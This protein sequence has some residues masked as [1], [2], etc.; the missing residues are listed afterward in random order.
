MCGGSDTPRI[1]R[2]IRV[3]RFA[4]VRGDRQPIVSGPPRDSPHRRTT[5]PIFTPS[6]A[7]P[8]SL[9]LRTSFG[10]S[11]SLGSRVGVR[12]QPSSTSAVRGRREVV[13][14]EKTGLVVPFGADR[15]DEFEP[16]TG[17][18]AARPG[19]AAANSLL[20]KSRGFL[21]DGQ[22]AL[23]RDAFGISVAGPRMPGSHYQISSGPGQA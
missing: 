7:L 10:S 1:G 20:T 17:D 6:R 22:S 14:H 5:S 12:R 2:E 21:Q 23:A 8:L 9:G 13:V 11:R 18:V 4:C 16:K 3:G 15:A 19:V